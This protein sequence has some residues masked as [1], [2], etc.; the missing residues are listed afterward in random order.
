MSY[1]N[2]E[3]SRLHGTISDL[4]LKNLA[5]EEENQQLRQHLKMELV[6]TDEPSVSKQSRWQRFKQWVDD[7]FHEHSYEVGL[8]GAFWNALVQ[9]RKTG[10]PFG[11]KEFFFHCSVTCT[12]CDHVEKKANMV[13][14][15]ISLTTLIE[16]AGVVDRSYMRLQAKYPV[17]QLPNVFTS[18]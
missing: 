12:E 14:D 15:T 11:R 6:R 18:A 4:K 3:F 16:V 10:R 17:L 13:W 8:D 5:L 9:A 7:L 2:P 1:R